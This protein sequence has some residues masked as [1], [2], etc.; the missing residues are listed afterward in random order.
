MSP[1]AEPTVVVTS[2]RDEKRKVGEKSDVSQD[3][4]RPEKMMDLTRLWKEVLKTKE[5]QLGGHVSGMF[6][7]GT[8]D[9]GAVEGP[10]RREG[11]AP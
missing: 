9:W 3:V 6:Q 10:G 1:I 7:G 11:L 8:E 2:I 5:S 4:R